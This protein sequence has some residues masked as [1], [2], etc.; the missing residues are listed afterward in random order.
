MRIAMLCYGLNVGGVQRVAV[1]LSNALAELGEEVFFLFRVNGLF[2]EE[3]SPNVKAI[4]YAS[5]Y[6]SYKDIRTWMTVFQLQKLLKNLHVN[7]VHSYDVL[8]WATGTIACRF[9]NIPIVRTQPNFIRQYERLNVKTLRLFP[10][11]KWTAAF[12]AIFNSTAQDLKYAGVNPSKVFVE[13]G[14]LKV[15]Y[16]GKREETRRRYNITEES[17][18]VI[19]VGRLVEGKGFELIPEI[20]RSVV[21]EVP[22]VYFWIIG[23]GPLKSL[24]EE[25]ARRRGVDNVVNFL[26]ERSDVDRLYEAADVALFPTDTH[27]GMCEAIAYIPLVTGQ[28][29]CQKEYVIPGVTGIL[30]NNIKEYTEALIYL[31]KNDNIRSQYAENARYLFHK[32]FSIEIGAPHFL[33]FYKNIIK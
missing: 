8:S 12:H 1:N 33:E 18:I 29:R 13:S 24:L 25:L 4:Q 10:F 30:C 26:G 11:E 7:L 19:S 28:G 17:K 9:N 16:S 31:L 15:K 32:K 20:A 21:K 2:R 23:A 14:I 6:P 5:G 3:L 27:A 22:N